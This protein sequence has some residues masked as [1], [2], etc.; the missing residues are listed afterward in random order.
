LRTQR[1]SLSSH[2]FFFFLFPYGQALIFVFVGPG[3]EKENKEK[4]NVIQFLGASIHS[5]CDHRRMA[6]A[7]KTGQD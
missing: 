6:A 5:L 3:R 7:Q 1:L 4:R 2:F